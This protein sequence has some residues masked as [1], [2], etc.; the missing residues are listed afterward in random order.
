MHAYNRVSSGVFDFLL[1]PFGHGLPGFDL[2][3]WPL[4]MLAFLG[5]G[6][7]LVVASLIP[8][9]MVASFM[10][11]GM[12]GIWLD[13]MSIAALIISL[14]MLVDNAIVMSESIMVQIGAGKRP[15]DAAVDSA[16]ELRVPLLTSSLTTAAAFL[17]I[18]LAEST[19]G[20][21]TAA[22][23][24]VVTITLL[25]SWLLALTMIPV[26]CVKFLRIPKAPKGSRYD[27]RFYHYYRAALLLG[28]RRR[29]L[30]LGMIGLVF[31]L[32]LVTGE[33]PERE[34]LL[35]AHAPVASR[36]DVTI[37]IPGLGEVLV[38]VEEARR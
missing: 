13:Q 22:L 3:I 37:V 15:F 38:D 7:G 28:L 33:A 31:A 1:A 6:T 20:E 32:A 12:L 9:A 24:K 18:Y 19:T 10:V 14:G 34:W 8:M 36:T 17:P 25:C 5:L 21:Y 29:W 11:M 16:A 30:S 27:S 4:V 2:L 26:L 23:F 35:Y